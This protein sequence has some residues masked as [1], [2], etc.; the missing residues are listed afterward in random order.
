M[1]DEVKLFEQ[2][3]ERTHWD[4]KEEKWYSDVIA[5]VKESIDPLTYWRKIKERLKK[6]MKP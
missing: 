2:Q 5:I 1:R 6:E 4:E 3:K